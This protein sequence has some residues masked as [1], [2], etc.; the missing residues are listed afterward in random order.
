M[1]LA[2]HRMQDPVACM[3][4]TQEP[5]NLKAI[6]NVDCPAV[7]WQRQPM[8]EFQGWINS[9]DS[10]TL[11][12]ARLILRPD[13]VRDAMETLCQ[14]AQTPDS[15]HRDRLIDDIAA[16]ADIFADVMQ[17]PF[18]QVRL[19]KVTTNACRKFHIDALTA[20]LICTYRGAGT[21]Y[22]VS[23]TPADPQRVF[24]VPTGTPLVLRGTKWPT[25]PA[26][27]LLHRSPPIEGSGET[28]LVLVL[29][30]VLN[31]ADG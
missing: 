12:S 5:E 6:H 26:S 29:D 10:E 22:G 28:R 30:P 11:P 25:R 7:I 23:H 21:Q 16:L 19:D 18:L 13:M 14:N 15:P 1:S 9:L 17:T 24:S 8:Q 3:T 20:R 27:G 31:E 4:I 2:E